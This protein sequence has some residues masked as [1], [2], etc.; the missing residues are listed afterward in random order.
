[1]IRKLPEREGAI[2]GV[3]VFERIDKKEQDAWIEIFDNIVKEHGRINRLVL[4]A[5]KI[6]YGVDA[7]YDDLKWTLDHDI[8]HAYA[9]KRKEESRNYEN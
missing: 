3:E 2:I 6:N 4:L 7:A 1:M 5:G 8:K 9:H